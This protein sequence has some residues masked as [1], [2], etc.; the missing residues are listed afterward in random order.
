VASTASFAA[1][2]NAVVSGWIAAQTNLHDW[3]A[4]FV[5]TRHLKALTR[6]LTASGHLWFA[7]PNQFR[8]ELRT[9]GQTIALRQPD[10]MWVIYPLL[11]RAERY[12]VG[13]NASGEWRDAL[14]LL[15]AGFPRNRAEFDARFRVLALIETN[16]AWQLE[17]QP[18]STLARKMMN[19]IS[20]GL[21]TND[22]TLTSTEMEFVDGSTM[23]NDF[24][25]ALRN[26]GFGRNV[27]SWEPPA[28]FTITHPLGK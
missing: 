25:N 20:V 23:R 12:P 8:W 22:Y 28:D 16:S 1:D 9:P 4:D 3:H 27:F 11:K 13:A 17:L 7:P 6:P 24:T 10:T 5:Q 2:T 26:T 14:A 21:A 19:R 15:E 18:T